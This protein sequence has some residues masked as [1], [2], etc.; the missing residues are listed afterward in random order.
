VSPEEIA[1]VYPKV[2]AI[3]GDSLGRDPE[4]I[5]PDNALIDD[6]GA[7]SIDFLDIVYRL[8]RSFHVKIPRG[9]I[10]EQAR[11]GLTEQE[12][13]QQGV[14]TAV[15]IA[16]LREFL[17]EVPASRFRDRMKLTD[18]PSLFTVETFCKIVVRSRRR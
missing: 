18:I 15:G 4:D 8:E 3:I 6:L 1:A 13:E 14:L 10:E 9:Q 2:A 7:E 16:R 12:F 17:N 5:A 11:G